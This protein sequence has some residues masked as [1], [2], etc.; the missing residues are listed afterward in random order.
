MFPRRNYHC[1]LNFPGVSLVWGLEPEGSLPRLC[2]WL[3]SG[4]DGVLRWNVDSEEKWSL[5]L[6]PG[7]L[8]VFC[9]LKKLA[10]FLS[11]WI[12]NTVIYCVYTL[13]QLP[14]CLSWGGGL[15]IIKPWICLGLTSLS[16]ETAC[17]SC[18]LEVSM[19]ALFSAESFLLCCFLKNLKVPEPLGVYMCLF[20]S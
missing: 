20:I 13:V 5:V 1:W 16:T 18:W 17:G 11:R 3:V 2:P 6:L 7:L 14:A 10:W 15:L 8:L 19:R 9:F 4:I 12:K